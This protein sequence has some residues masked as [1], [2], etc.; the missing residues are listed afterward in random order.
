MPQAKKSR[1]V[2]TG[3][4]IDAKGGSVK[5]GSL[6]DLEVKEDGT[7]VDTL[8]ASRVRP[9]SG[10]V[11]GD[12]AADLSTSVSDAVQAEIEKAR[13]DLDD[14]V[15][16]RLTAA[17]KEAAEILEKANK[18]AEKIIQDASQAADEIKAEAAKK[19]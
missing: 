6:I 14:E 12:S 11:I 13:K 1:F 3:K 16:S 15:K 7:P 5:A 9:Y 18:E 17:D 19:K 10:K 4:F 2:V 8:L